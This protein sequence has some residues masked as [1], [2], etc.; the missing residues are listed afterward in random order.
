MLVLS[1]K[2]GEELVIGKGIQVRVL[3]VRGNHVRLGFVAPD[4]VTIHRREIAAGNHRTADSNR[5]EPSSTPAP[6]RTN[7]LF[8]STLIE[9]A[10]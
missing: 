6:Q 3:E 9:A 7:P 8:S 4:N 10:R 1:R 5:I 2:P